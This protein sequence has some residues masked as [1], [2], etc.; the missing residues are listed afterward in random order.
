MKLYNLHHI[1]TQSGDS[2]VKDAVMIFGNKKNVWQGKILEQCA[3]NMDAILLHLK[4]DEE[5]KSHHHG[6]SEEIIYILKGEGIITQE[7]SE[8]LNVK[9]GDLVFLE[10][11]IRHSIKGGK[12][13][14]SCLCF[15]APAMNFRG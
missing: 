1:K 14:L 12:A 3:E 10:K 9:D 15:H 6:E 11:N 5:I 4:A 8:I 13:E 7:N 2:Y